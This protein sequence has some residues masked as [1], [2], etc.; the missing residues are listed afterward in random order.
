[1]RWLNQL[2]TFKDLQRFFQGEL[3]E[4]DEGIMVALKIYLLGGALVSSGLWFGLSGV[5]ETFAGHFSTLFQITG[6]LVMG[7]SVLRYSHITDP[8]RPVIQTW[9]F[10]LNGLQHQFAVIRRHR[11]STGLS[12]SGNGWRQEQADRVALIWRYCISTKRLQYLTETG[13]EFSEAIDLPGAE[14]FE[15]RFN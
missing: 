5:A 1:M 15:T 3:A 10:E 8:K 14:N 2:M 9:R 7:G 11:E 12:Y 6:L 13:E 4:T